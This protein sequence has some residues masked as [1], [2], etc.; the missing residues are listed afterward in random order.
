M[1]DLI[2]TTAARALF[3]L[4]ILFGVF[5]VVRGHNEPG[6]GFAGG[7]VVS[8]AFALYSLAY[9]P[10]TARRLLRVAPLS[11]VALGLI[12]AGASGVPALLKG[13][14]F[15]QAQWLSV[16]LAGS[17]QFKVGTPLMFDIGVF[18]VV[19]GMVTT[20]ILALQEE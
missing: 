16:D 6:G 17:V 1:T 12:T 15:M 9:D 7:L 20:I 3:P 18:L 2:F 5:L 4:F 8:A 10:L 13:Q 14:P 11:L 19:V